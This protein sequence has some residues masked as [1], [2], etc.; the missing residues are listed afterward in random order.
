[1]SFNYAIDLRTETAFQ[2]Q[3]PN[4]TQ[5]KIK[6]LETKKKQQQQQEDREG[7]IK[8]EKKLLRAN[9]WERRTDS[10]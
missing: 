3:Q 10:G 2:W 4:T 6:H 5:K 8:E 1:M 7:K 9:K